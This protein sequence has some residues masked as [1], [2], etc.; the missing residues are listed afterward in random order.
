MSPTKSKADIYIYDDLHPEDNAMLQALYSRSPNTVVEHVKKV[1][2]SGSGKFMERFYIGY[3]H[4]SIGDCGS[5]TIFIENVSMMVAKAI[6]D[7]PLYSGQ[8]ASTRYLDFSK[9]PMI[10]PYKSPQSAAIQKGWTDIYNRYMPE[11]KAALSQIY[12]FDEKQHRSEQSWEKAISARAFDTLRSLLPAGT[13]TLLSW[14]T[15]LR[16]ARDHLRHL[17]SHPLSEIRAVACDIYEA[18]LSRYGNSFNGQEMQEDCERYR[19]RD[20]FAR[21]NSLKNHILMPDEVLQ[22]LSEADASRV[23]KGELVFDDSLVNVREANRRESSVFSGRPKGAPLSRRMLQYGIYNMYFLL[24][25]GSFRDV[26]RHRNGYC[27]VPLI[28]GKFGFHSWYLKELESVLAPARFM[29]LAGEIEGMLKRIERLSIPGKDRDLLKDQY[30]Y[31]MGMACLCQLSYGIPQMVYVSELRSQK[32]VHPSLRTI[33]RQM[34]SE[35]Q[36][37]HPDLNLYIDNDEDSWTARRGDQDIVEKRQ[38]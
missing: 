35:L 12:P 30:L 8:E 16:Q 32:T 10:D 29:A 31:P 27:P 24:D 14:H 11:V 3:G 19:E 18:L 22:N 37:R 23:K 1:Q 5:T 34:G 28:S 33:A 13:G 25:F 17:K 20:S 7:N 6:Q 36:Q 15:N 4:S 2:E 38:A 26:Q 9:Q 21:I